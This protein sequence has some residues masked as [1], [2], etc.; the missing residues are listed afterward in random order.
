[1]CRTRRLRALPLHKRRVGVVL[2]YSNFSLPKLTTDVPEFDQ[3][4][5]PS[6][7]EQSVKQ[8]A[9]EALA[10]DDER[11]KP[12][13]RRPP[14]QLTDALRREVIHR[15]QAGQSSRDIAKVMGMARSTL[16]GIL[17]RAGIE[18]RPPHTR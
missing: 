11:V 12:L 6:L 3:V 17:D 16:L 8:E 7:R 13:T 1:M 9:P 15:Y 5:G 4:L 2:S 10:V 14:I 18:K